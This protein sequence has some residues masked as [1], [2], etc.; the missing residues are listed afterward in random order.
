MVTLNTNSMQHF[1]DIGVSDWYSN[2]YLGA[3]DRLCAEITSYGFWPLFVPNSNRVVSNTM[4]LIQRDWKE[5]EDFW[6]KDI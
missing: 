1:E 2:M 3:C 4:K 6:L 5:G